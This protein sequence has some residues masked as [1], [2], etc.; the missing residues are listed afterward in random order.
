[1][2]PNG[3]SAPSPGRKATFGDPTISNFPAPAHNFSFLRI[4]S[5]Y[6]FQRR[7]EHR[8]YL[9]NSTGFPVLQISGLTG[10]MENGRLK[11]HRF[12]I[13]A[14]ASVGSLLSVA[15]FMLQLN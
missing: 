3:P 5:V 10:E 2:L 6:L 14:A 4:F 13:Q 12:T 15:R 7:V 9:G 8:S 1:M 11:A